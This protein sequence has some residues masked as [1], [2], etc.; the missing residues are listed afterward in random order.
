M[1]AYGVLRIVGAAEMK[2]HD[3][4][5][6]DFHVSITVYSTGSTSEF[7]VSM[8][9]VMK[10]IRQRYGYSDKFL[11]QEGCEERSMITMTENYYMTEEAWKK[12]IQNVLEGYRKMPLV[13]DNP[14]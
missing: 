9:F 5:V 11:V 3:K 8:T 14:N 2:N 12:M 13:R 7:N 1:D 10:D 6:S 4:R